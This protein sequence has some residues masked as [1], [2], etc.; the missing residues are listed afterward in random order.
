M[1]SKKN[2]IDFYEVLEIN[3]DATLVQIKQSYRKLALVT[4]IIYLLILY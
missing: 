3:K 4:Y 2:K 1:E